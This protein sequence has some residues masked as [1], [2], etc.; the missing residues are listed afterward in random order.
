MLDRNGLIASLYSNHGLLKERLGDHSA[1]IADLAKALDFDSAHGTAYDNRGLSYASLGKYTQAK[2][3]FT[4]AI[5]V[6]PK[7]RSAFCN[8]GAACCQL[9]Q[10]EEA[11]KDLN[12][13]VL[14]GA[15]D[16][17]VFFNRGI[18]LASLGRLNEARGDLLEAGMKNPS[19]R[20][21]I[22]T[23][24]SQLKLNIEFPTGSHLRSCLVKKDGSTL[25]GLVV[26]DGKSEVCAGT[27]GFRAKEGGTFYTPTDQLA[28]LFSSA[29][30]QSD[31]PKPLGDANSL[32]VILEP[33]DS[34]FL[35]R[36]IAPRSGM[37]FAVTP[38]L[39]V[40]QGVKSD[41][42]A[43]AK[44]VRVGKGEIHI[45][46]TQ[47]GRRVGT[48]IYNVADNAVITYS[49]DQKKILAYGIVHRFVPDSK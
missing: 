11:V 44:W 1:A 7:H 15:R 46:R 32:A 43:N 2:S 16:D 49:A 19:R 45:V 21:A 20:A 30:I 29:S 8:R 25:W 31:P 12:R 6:D 34:A 9:R 37:L 38:E 14:L 5:E 23:A 24:S 27:V 10:Y 33:T 48:D 4:K 28:V 13:A 41:I 3:D 47:D 22:A 18:A 39:S 35:C 36:A 26:F 17:T 42:Q 40:G